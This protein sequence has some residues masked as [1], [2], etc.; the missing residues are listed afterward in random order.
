MTL[1]EGNDLLV[2]KKAG[3]TVELKDGDD[4]LKVK[5]KQGTLK[6]E[7]MR[8]ASTAATWSST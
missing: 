3:R 7:A 2:L 8:S 1:K 5:G 6:R 4:G